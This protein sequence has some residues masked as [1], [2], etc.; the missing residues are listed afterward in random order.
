MF[1]VNFVIVIIMVIVLQFTAL[2]TRN[3]FCFVSYLFMLCVQHVFM[4]LTLRLLPEVVFSAWFLYFFSV[5]CVRHCV[6][7]KV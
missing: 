7:R 3:L 5:Y 4:Q 2:V 6:R 1:I